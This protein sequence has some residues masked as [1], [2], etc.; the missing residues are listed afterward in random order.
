MKK[1][2]IGL[3][4]LMMLFMMASCGGA[5][6]KIESLTKDVEKNSEDWDTEKWVSVLTDFYETSIEFLESEPSEKDFDKFDDAY[7]DFK[8]AVRDSD[9]NKKTKAINK[10]EIQKLDGKFRKAY[11]KAKKKIDKD[12]D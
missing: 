1:F 3:C 11:S 6:G 8:D 7:S 12:D 4:A 5:V 2:I 10:K 9:S